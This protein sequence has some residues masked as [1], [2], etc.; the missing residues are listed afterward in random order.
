MNIH[1]ELLK[2]KNKIENPYNKELI[3]TGKK[4]EV[5]KSKDEARGTQI[6]CDASGCRLVH[7]EVDTNKRPARRGFGGRN[8]QSGM[9][10]SSVR[11]GGCG[12][13]GR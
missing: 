13:C 12:S 3:Q 8:R 1:S 10:M 5:N 2:F 11:L 4:S 7:S 6:S 9:G